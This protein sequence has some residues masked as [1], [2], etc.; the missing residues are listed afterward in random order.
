MVKTVLLA[1][2]YAQ[3]LTVLL[4]MTA[5]DSSRDDSLFAEIEQAWL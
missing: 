4:H 2:C 5:I 1:A 3:Q